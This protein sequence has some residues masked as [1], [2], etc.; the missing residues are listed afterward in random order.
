MAFLRRS[1]QLIPRTVL[2]ERMALVAVAALVLVSLLA[3]RLPAYSL[4]DLEVLLLLWALL[5]TVRGLLLQ[6]WADRVVLVLERHGDP[7]PMLVLGTFLLAMFVTND[8]ALVVVVPL[9]LRTRGLRHGRVVV[10]EALAAN[11]GS[12]LTPLGNPQNLYIFWHFGISAGNFLQQMWPLAG[13][14]LVFLLLAARLTGRGEGG[15]PEAGV[16]ARGGGGGA[17]LPFLWLLLIIATVLR[18]VPPPLL[19]VPVADAVVRDRRLL[20]VDY[21]LLVILACLFGL[22]D[23]ATALFARRLGNPAHVFLAGVGLSQLVSN[24]PAAVILADLTPRWGALLWGVNA[25][26]FFGLIGSLANLIAYRLYA[27]REGAT[28]RDDRRFVVLLL[29]AGGLNL[30]LVAFLYHLIHG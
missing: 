27:G 5:V 29:V 16:P 4:S 26:G 19:A 14:S 24:V 2:R 15:S 28:P 11:A 7:S 13:V 10:L 25:G 21:G 3:R 17:P 1:A 23:Q 8:V 30:L 22:A 12:A 18:L 6:G 20:R 9:T